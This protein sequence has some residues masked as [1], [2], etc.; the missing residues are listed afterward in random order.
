MLRS[1]HLEHV[2]ITNGDAERRPDSKEEKS[3]V[4]GGN[5]KVDYVNQLNEDLKNTAPQ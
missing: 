5:V 4:E 3:N 1:H 2:D